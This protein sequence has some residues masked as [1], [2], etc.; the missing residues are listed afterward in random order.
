[1]E[2]IYKMFFWIFLF[3]LF[4]F[5]TQA[6]V[7]S[8][9]LIHQGLLL[10][11]EGVPLGE[12]GTEFCFKFS[13]YDDGE[14]GIPDAKLWPAGEPSSVAI[15]VK[16]GFFSATIG[17]RESDTLN[18]RESNKN[19]FLQLETAYKIGGSCA[20]SDEEFETL[21]PRQAISL[22]T[23]LVSASPLICAEIFTKKFTLEQN[24]RIYLPNGDNQIAGHGL[25]FAGQS[26]AFIPN[27]SIE[28]SSFIIITPVSFISFP[29]YIKEKRVGGFVVATAMASAEDIIF[30]WIVFH[31]AQSIAS[32]LEL[33][34]SGNELDGGGGDQSAVTFDGGASGPPIDGGAGGGSS[35]PPAL[36]EETDLAN[37]NESSSSTPVMT[38]EDELQPEPF[39]E[40]TLEQ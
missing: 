12:E 6:E 39:T 9:R 23:P 19:F 22:P 40:Q 24:G 29:L 13:I 4:P 8:G 27:N 36:P 33:E 15:M 3:L 30:D 20:D 38:P 2:K 5:F 1:M 34:A 16:N 10:D 37:L 35:T 18:L 7:G 31:S 25:I 17:D 11:S 28:T 21:E 26:E 14:V 32:N